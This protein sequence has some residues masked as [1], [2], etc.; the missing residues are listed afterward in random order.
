MPCCNGRS[1]LQCVKLPAHEPVDR[2]KLYATKRP[3]ASADPPAWTL[4]VYGRII[5]P[6]PPAAAQGAPAVRAQAPQPLSHYVRSLSVELDPEQYP[7][8][9]GVVEWHRAQH[10]GPHCESFQ[11]KCDPLR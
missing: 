5:D 3:C 2:F 11:I 8:P 7:R 9:A 6:N 1:H 10:L 4:H